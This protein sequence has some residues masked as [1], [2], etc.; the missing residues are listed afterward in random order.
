M[1]FLIWGTRNRTVQLN[2][3]NI[4]FKCTCNSELFN[5]VY[6]FKNHHIFWIPISKY[7]MKNIH[8]QCIKCGKV[9]KLE[10]N[11]EKLAKQIYF[12]YKT[13]KNKIN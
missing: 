6:N 8:I 2:G 9:Y 3:L 4:G 1:F 5:I 13:E 12:K 11:L 10:K 7:K